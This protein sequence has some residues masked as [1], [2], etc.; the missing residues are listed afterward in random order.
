L[1]TEI[2][3]NREKEFSE[4]QKV[5]HKLGYDMLKI[6]RENKRAGKRPTIVKRL[7]QVDGFSTEEHP[8]CV[9]KYYVIV[10]KLGGG[11][12]KR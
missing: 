4:F 3:E 6:K 5:M 10:Q 11:V 2:G 12:L 9:G 8:I 7:F 1:N